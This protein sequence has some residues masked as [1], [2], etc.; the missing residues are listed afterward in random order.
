MV[1]GVERVEPDRIDRLGAPQAQGVHGIAAPADD[2]RVVGDSQHF[3][4]GLPG[5]TLRAVPAGFARH[6]AAEANLVDDLAALE[7]PGVAEGEPVLRRLDLRAVDHALLEQAVIVA[8]AVAEP[9]DAERRHALHEA[10]GEPPE[11]AVAERGVRF[12]LRDGIEIEADEGERLAH[13]LLEAEIA[14]RILEQAAD[15]KFEREIIDP[16][17]TGA[18]GLA[19]RG[20]PAVDDLVAHRQDRRGQPVVVERERRRLADVVDELGLDFL[21]QRLNGCGGLV[22][23]ARPPFDRRENFRR[24]QIART[25]ANK[26]F[27][28]MPYS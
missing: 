18:L 8:D 10:G 20:H 23:G 3:F 24:L 28:A 5:M 9:R 12:E 15:Q 11:A 19:D 22:P 13:L 7:F 2:R 27:D 21:A 6:F 4:G 1:A 14:E 16:L 17:A 26:P 25:H